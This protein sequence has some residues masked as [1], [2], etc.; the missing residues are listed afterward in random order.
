MDFSGHTA[1]SREVI[2][3]LRQ[4][5]V[6]MDSIVHNPHAK[7]RRFYSAPVTLASCHDFD[8]TLNP[9]SEREEDR[10]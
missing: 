1:L 10:K 4:A 3:F 5:A 9:S 2:A 8:V 6:S 7:S